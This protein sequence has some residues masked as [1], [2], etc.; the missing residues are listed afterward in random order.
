[1]T[2]TT[3]DPLSVVHL[4]EPALL[5]DPYPFYHRLRVE[6]PVHW[7]E[8]MGYWVVTR[9]A[10]VVAALR[11][12]RLSAART[13]PSVDAWLPPELHEALGPVV[14]AIMRQMLFLDPPDHTRL[15]GLVNKAF[16]PRTV[17]AMRAHIQQI[18]DGLLDRMQADGRTEMDVIAELAYPLPAIVIAEMLGVPPEDRDQFLLW[19]NDFGLILDD[20]TTGEDSMR[21][22]YGVA[23]F[24]AYFRRIIEDRRAAPRDDVLG[25]LITAEEAGDRLSTD[26]LLGNC[27]LLLAAGHGT[28]THLIGN[29]LLALLRHSEQREMFR[30][31]PALGP[32]AVTE[33][34]RYDAPVQSTG[35]LVTQDLELAGILLRAGQ[36]VTLRLG[37]ANR[38]PAQFPDPDRLDLT[39]RDTRHVAFGYGIHFC[40]GAPLAR[41]E[42]EI[43]FNTILRRLPGLRL[44]HESLAWDPGVVFRG[45][46]SLPVAFDRIV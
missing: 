5:A 8:E 25:S 6:A 16:T 17:E 9:Y 30:A 18:V 10:D 14:R 15:R 3:R 40:V 7:D 44:V 33:L 37:A 27:I 46:S 20:T 21:A 32:S 43:A 29:G 34:L 13:A 42:G 39:R 38:D 11:D 35:R 45:L 28:T 1:M 2:A 36:H 22:M 41:L 23:A 26:E 12:P 19:S 31:D 4:L 24:I